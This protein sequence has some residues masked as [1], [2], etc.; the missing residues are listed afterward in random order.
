MTSGCERGRSGRLGADQSARGRAR[1]RRRR[2]GAPGRLKG[3]LVLLALAGL[4][5]GLLLTAKVSREL[6]LPLRD[7]SIIRRQ[8]KAKHLDPALIAAVIDAETKFLPR[9]SSAGA[10]G[11]MQILPSTAEFLAK[12]TGGYAFRTSD[13]NQPAVNIAY[14]SWYLRYLLDHYDGDELAAVAAYNAGMTNVERW[15]E[16]ARSHGRALT[17]KDIAFPQTAEYV[18]T[19]L[20]AEAA[21]RRLYA[22]QLGID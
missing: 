12:L 1:P 22:K 19:V 21:Y 20:S 6:R 11:L 16:S 13:L 17:L 9:E 8:A 5:A 14:G 3:L 10:Q 18:R 7:E 2:S 4:T 15:R